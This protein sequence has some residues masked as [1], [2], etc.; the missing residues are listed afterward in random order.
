MAKLE[1][2]LV[3]N[4]NTRMFLGEMSLGNFSSLDVPDSVKEITINQLKIDDSQRVRILNGLKFENINTIGDLL[5]KSQ[6]EL[7]RIPNFGR[8][9]LGVLLDS[10]SIYGLSI[11]R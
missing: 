4:N 2:F 11:K 6:A 10:I 5:E 7:L 8:K 3:T 1:I 9:S